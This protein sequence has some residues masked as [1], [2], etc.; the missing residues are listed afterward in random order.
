MH[1]I[2]SVA[3]MPLAEFRN[4]FRNTMETLK[5]HFGPESGVVWIELRD[6]HMQEPNLV[7]V[8]S[9]SCIDILEKMR[10]IRGPIV[11]SNNGQRCVVSAY[12]QIVPDS[13]HKPDQFVTWAI[14]DW[15][16]YEIGGRPLRYEEG[17][18]RDQQYQ[19]KVET[20]IDMMLALKS[21][22]REVLQSM[23]S[24]DRNAIRQCLFDLLAGKESDSA[25]VDLVKP[26]VD[27]FKKGI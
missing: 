16:N 12:S 20:A 23:Y 18:E 4:L 7:T 1:N 21:V 27:L 22:N 25:F 13:F 2:Q 8:N 9:R 3:D 11:V 14:S 19:E 24:T 6:T 10:G 15:A 17:I 5:G 26:H